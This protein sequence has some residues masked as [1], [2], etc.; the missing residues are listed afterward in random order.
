MRNEKPEKDQNKIP[1]LKRSFG[2]ICWNFYSFGKTIYSTF[3]IYKQIKVNVC[4]K[5]FRAL[6][7]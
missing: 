6:L 4:K 5:L 2:R 3:F 1:T 7:F